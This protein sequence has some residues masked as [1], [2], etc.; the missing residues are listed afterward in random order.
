MATFDGAP[1]PVI[2]TAAPGGYRILYPTGGEE[3]ANRAGAAIAVVVSGRSLPT[4]LM[5]GNEV[6]RFDIDLP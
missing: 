6:I 3:C 4:G 2:S 5:V 1:G